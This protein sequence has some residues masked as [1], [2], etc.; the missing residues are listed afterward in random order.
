MKIAVWGSDTVAGKALSEEFQQDHEVSAETLNSIPLTEIDQVCSTN[1]VLIY[2]GD[3]SASSWDS[4]F[5][6]LTCDLNVVAKL[7]D[8]AQ[9]QECQFVFLSS[10]A[11][12]NGPWLFHDEYTSRCEKTAI[13]RRIKKLEDIVLNYSRGTVIRSNILGTSE[14]NSSFLDELLD[15]VL[16][17]KTCR[18]DATTFSSPILVGDFARITALVVRELPTGIVHVSG[19]ERTTPWSFAIQLTSALGLPRT[20]I[21]PVI[22]D[23]ERTERSLRC[24]RLTG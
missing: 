12:F 11:V 17:G 9:T 10:D 22:N 5:G 15:N 24:E 1:D 14:D 23:H 3:T 20:L 13:A 6:N 7:V 2:C 19:A 4:G 8:A 18:V 16:S 21:Q